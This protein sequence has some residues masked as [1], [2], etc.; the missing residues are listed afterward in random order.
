MKVFVN[1]HGVS[2]LR[3]SL[4]ES[5]TFRVVWS[6]GNQE[7]VGTVEEFPML[8]HLDVRPTDALIGI[9]KLVEREL[10]DLYEE[11]KDPP[12][13]KGGKFDGKLAHMNIP[14]PPTGWVIISAYIPGCGG[15]KGALCL[16]NPREGV[17]RRYT[18]EVDFRGAGEFYGDIRSPNGDIV[19]LNESD[20]KE[21]ARLFFLLREKLFGDGNPYKQF[22]EE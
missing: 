4:A 19:W 14:I 3:P 12:K 10:H 7:F 11:G 18:I 5:Y 9:T 1:D 16:I 8:C 22:W 21:R 6:E 13:P 17:I 2:A 15:T 20:F